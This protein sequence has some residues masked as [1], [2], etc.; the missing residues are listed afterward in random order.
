M[1]IPRRLIELLENDLE[2]AWNRILRRAIEMALDFLEDLMAG[3][4]S[5]L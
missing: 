4:P 3:N 5:I 2:C 1:G